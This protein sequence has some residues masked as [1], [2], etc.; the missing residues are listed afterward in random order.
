MEF[1]PKRNVRRAGFTLVELL[2]V[3]GILV[4]LLAMVVPRLL[5]SR[6]R[7]Q[8]D[9]A[10]TQIGMFRGP[11]EQYFLD[12]NQF[13]STEQGLEALVAQ[14]ADLPENVTWQGPYVNGNLGNDPWNNPY[15]YEYP[16]THGNADTPDIWSYG[17][18]GEEGTDDDVT[19]WGGGSGGGGEGELG[20]GEMKP[21]RGEGMPKGEGP[22]REGRKSKPVVPKA[23]R[24]DSPEKSRSR[25]RISE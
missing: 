22:P 17:P 20:S 1:T 21:P 24:S 8:I 15:Q 4:L 12:C 6:K 14:P 16:P 18:D 7:A 5:G 13:P 3:L 10:K 23:I 9:A 19:S 25:T 2:I 11:L